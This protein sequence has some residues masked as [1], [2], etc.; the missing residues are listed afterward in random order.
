[1]L[2]GDL[3][4]NIIDAVQHRLETKYPFPIVKNGVSIMD[5]SDEGNRPSHRSSQGSC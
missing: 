3:G 4:K 1:M 5:G 2:E